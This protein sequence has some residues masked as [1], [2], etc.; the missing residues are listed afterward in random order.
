MTP[1]RFILAVPSAAGFHEL[2][3]EMAA[4]EEILGDKP[5]LWR[6]PGTPMRRTADKLVI[7]AT[8]APDGTPFVNEGIYAATEAPADIAGSMLTRCWGAYCALM[9]DR[10][11]GTLLLLLDPSGLL[12]V[13]R[14]ATASHLVLMSHPALLGSALG[15]KLAVDYGAVAEHLLQPE[16][17]GTR[18]CLAELE[19]VAPG[20]LSC[21]TRQEQPVKH[22]W[23]PGDHIETR[24]DRSLCD[25]AAELR[26]IGTRVMGSWA[27]ELG[28]PDVAVSGGVDSSF[29]CA[30]L[31]N[32]K[33]PF[34]CATLA[35]AD[36]SGDER[37]YAR[38]IAA[39]FG[40]QLAE[41][42]YDVGS[43]D[44]KQTASRHLPRPSRRLF[45]TAVDEHL[46]A[47]RQQNASAVTFDGNGG[48]NVFCLLHST[49]PVIDRVAAE[50]LG[51]GTLETMIDLSTLTGCSLPTV[52]AASIRRA[53]RGNSAPIR[54]ADT[55]LLNREYH[56]VRGAAL[57]PW[58]SLVRRVLPGQREHI[59]M[60]MRMQN[61][62]HALS[63]DLG[64]FSP[65]ASQPLVEFCLGVP[66]WLWAR[67]GRNRA[68]ARAAFADLLPSTLLQ[69][70]SKAGPDSFVRL[71]FATN[72]ALISERL[73]DGLLSRN[74]IVDRNALAVA[75]ASSE[76]SESEDCLRVLDLLEAENWARAWS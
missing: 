55:R 65:L 68:V 4:P 49:A 16:R 57:T 14:L 48:D 52:A 72:R 10:Q 18:T 17:R 25:C 23:S 2:P 53:L 7:G 15:L 38:Q 22:L 24:K 5:A 26:D 50:G 30:A 43:F 20:T 35:T 3:V 19:E 41:Q 54:S 37:Y 66:T 33:A 13:Y 34:A 6:S 28:R 45:Q 44:C 21:L 29:I 11:S 67:G 61:H 73:L 74:G 63:C 51:R 12:P 31:A 60:I 32:S 36:A 71:V 1:V 64:R 75:L 62:V 8:F 27:K 70:M 76:L 56:A 42:T 40:K 39:A 69:R 59:A 46:A 9:A 47:L 58:D